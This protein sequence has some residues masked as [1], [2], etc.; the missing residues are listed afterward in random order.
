MIGSKDKILSTANEWFD[1]SFDLERPFL[2]V[3]ESHANYSDEK[4]HKSNFKLSFEVIYP[5]GESNSTFRI[6]PASQKERAFAFDSFNIDLENAAKLRLKF[7]YQIEEQEFSG[8]LVRFLPMEYLEMNFPSGKFES[9]LKD[10]KNTKILFS[11]PYGQGK[12]TFLDVYFKTKFNEYNVF[13]VF[14]V[15]YSVASNEDIFRYIKSDILSQLLLKGVEF[16]INEIGYSKAFLEHVKNDPVKVFAPFLQSIPKVGKQIYDI[17]EQVR[18]KVFQ[19][20]EKDANQFVK[21]VYHEEG[22]IYEDNFFT[23]LIRHLLEKNKKLEGGSNVLVIDDLDRMDPD[24]IFRILNVIS[25]HYDTYRLLDDQDH[26]KFGFDKIIIVCDIENIRHIFRHKYGAKTDFEGYM[27]KFY[28]TETFHFDNKEVYLELIRSFKVRDLKPNYKKLYEAFEFISKCFIES[29][30]L[31]LREI[32]KLQMF[33]LWLQKREVG[34]LF[35]TKNEPYFMYALFTPII[36]LFS[37][38][39]SYDSLIQKFENCKT[40]E[41]EFGD[42]EWGEYAKLALVGIATGKSGKSLKYDYHGDKLNIG[43]E[44]DDYTLNKGMTLTQSSNHEEVLFNE[45]FS[46]EEFFDFLIENALRY[47]DL[48]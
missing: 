16:D 28:S 25:A 4:L 22:G 13:K 37:K 12:S 47:K 36:R 44:V 5:D 8:V 18:K 21:D 29:K 1:V 2:K 39:G 38:L 34:E 41:F 40:V 35:D 46:Q 9:H 20:D 15:N 31:S 42:R 43:V 7:E 48:V 10:P 14:P 30:Q 26:N 3:I 32:L 11:A 45:T 33:P 6:I 27:N 24:H 19:D 23:Q 17:F